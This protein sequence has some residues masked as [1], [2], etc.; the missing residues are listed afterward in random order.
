MLVK[1]REVM[2]REQAIQMIEGLF[3]ADSQYIKTSEIG[4]RL[5]AQAK[6]EVVG[7]RNEPT[8]VLI[9]YAELCMAEEN[10]QARR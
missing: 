6:M 4:E 8:D 3:P 2:E 1:G 10:R 5:L 9:R 7:W